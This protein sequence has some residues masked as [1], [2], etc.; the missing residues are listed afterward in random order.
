MDLLDSH[1]KFMKIAIEAG[2]ENVK[3]GGGPFGAVIVKD[4]KVIAVGVNR[5]TSSHDPTAHAEV[6]AIRTACSK[7]S[8]FELK[9]CI[10][11][12]SC[13]PCPMCLSASYWARIDS[14]YYAATRQDAANANFDDDFIYKEI[15]LN[16]QNRSIP[17][18]HI[19][20]SINLQP[21]DTWREQENK[22]LY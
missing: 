20:T 16:P 1:R 22:T 7:L 11:Y 17:C 2:T 12:T 6:N 18:V 9:G 8:D 4:G 13:E 14:I 21:F 3:K 15:P 19:N 5:V 10:L